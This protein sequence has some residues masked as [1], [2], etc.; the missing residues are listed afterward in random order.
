MV[1]GVDISIT[2]TFTPNASLSASVNQTSGLNWGNIIPGSSGSLAF[3]LSND[4]TVTIDSTINT[5]DVADD[6]TLVT[7][8]Q[9]DAVDE[10]SMEF[11]LD[12]ASWSDLPASPTTL[13]N[14]LASTG[15]TTQDFNIRIGLASEGVSA[16]HSA[17]DVAV[18]VS[19]EANT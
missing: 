5:S 9:L 2:G 12:D 17:Q 13:K 18:T 6:L 15:T 16:E 1:S 8:A 3:E 14:D 4:G 7:V 19:Y 10:Y 11:D